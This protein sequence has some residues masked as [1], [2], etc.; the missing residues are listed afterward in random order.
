MSHMEMLILLSCGGREILAPLLYFYA[1]LVNFTTS[2]W[3]MEQM[4]QAPHTFLIFP[5]QRMPLLEVS[6]SESKY[7]Q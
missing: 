2:L 4:W 1:F 5:F 7:V 3:R 6:L